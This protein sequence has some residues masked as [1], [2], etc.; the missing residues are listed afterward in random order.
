MPSKHLQCLSLFF[1]PLSICLS[2]SY[3]SYPRVANKF[4]LFS[5]ILNVR[6]FHFNVNIGMCTCVTYDSLDFLCRENVILIWSNSYFNPRRCFHSSFFAFADRNEYVRLGNPSHSIVAGN[7]LGSVFVFVFVVV[8][9]LLSHKIPS[10][11]CNIPDSLLCG[12]V[13]NSYAHVWQNGAHNF[14]TCTHA[15]LLQLEKCPEFLAY[16]NWTFACILLAVIMQIKT[17]H[18]HQKLGLLGQNFSVS[19]HF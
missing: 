6:A 8:L 4:L 12:K 18:H 1:F 2:V 16:S 11:A 14:H 15:F 10:E 19:L 17:K 7:V 5:F 9:L 3:S 13:R